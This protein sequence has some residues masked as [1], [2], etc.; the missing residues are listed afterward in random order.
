MTGSTHYDVIVIGSGFGGAVSALRLTEKG[1][2]VGVLEAGRRF[3]DADHART[4][5]HVRD[6]LWAP[7]LGLK[8][9]QRIHVLPHVVVL[10]GAGVGGGS[11]NYGGTLYR[12]PAAFYADS[13]WAG[14]TDWRAELEPHYD[15]AS[16]MLGVVTNP[17]TTP[18]DV[19]L[20]EVAGRLGVGESFT[21]T[22]VGVFFGPDGTPAPGQRCPDPFFGGAGPQRTGCTECGQCMSGCR[23]G[24]KNTL[25]KNYL[26]LAER[27]GAVLHSQTTV[28]RLVPVPGVG[29]GAAAGYRVETRSSG[30]WLPGSLGSRRGP[31]VF[32][33]DQVVLAAGTWG[34]Q[35]LLHRMKAG[36]Q[37]PG[38]SDRL[39]HLT[40]TNSESLG[41]AVVR[42]GATDVPDFTRG[43]AITCSI[44]PDERTHVEPCRYGRG[45]NAMGLLATL[46]TRGDTGAPRWR[47]WLAECARH[48]GRLAWLYA[49][50]RHQ[51]ERSLITLVM[52]SHD[53]SLTLRATR[54]RWGR[55][56]VTSDQGHG[57]PNPTWI[58][59]AHRVQ[60]AV[61]EVIDG[62]AVNTVGEI[63]DIPMTAHFLG[64]CVIGACP[65]EG[66]IDAY[67]RVFGHP[68]LHVVDGSAISA[69]LGVNPALTITAQAERAMSFWPNRGEPDP[70]PAPGAAYQRLDPVAPL[71]PA[72]PDHAPAALRLPIVAP[73]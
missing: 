3:A 66:V 8:G 72:V 12:P 54:S 23:Q 71:R 32:T 44:Q 41:G 6:Y 34:T 1:Y 70:R 30:S 43:V 51:S 50:L 64:G 62:F 20:R 53:N 35:Q 15:Q 67:H 25:V 19:V 65:Q 49:G 9:V 58:E 55:I 38:L 40:R 13:Q 46:A 17:T 60:E 37:L 26:H 73:Q 2:R 29:S 42:R 48:P 5:W 33:A 21:P 68:G 28:T 11:L 52:Q 27:A 10:A 18:S 31:Q 14:L 22:R 4:T 36:G 63:A 24:A 47:A 7:R 16:R 39:G 69:N 57:E 59:Q 45:S 61:A 56:T